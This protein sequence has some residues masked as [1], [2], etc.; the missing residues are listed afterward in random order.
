MKADK[1]HQLQ[2]NALADGVGR[3]VQGMR[4]SPTSRSTLAWVFVVLAIVVVV[5]WQYAAHATQAQYSAL[6]SDV[7]AASHDAVDGLD[8]LRQVAGE[9]Q[10]TF[11]ARSARFEFARLVLQ[12]GQEGIRNFLDRENAVKQLVLARSLYQKLLPECTDSTIL[13]HEAMMGIAQ[14]EESLVGVPNPDNPSEIFD[15]NTALESYRKLAEQ[16]KAHPDSPLAQ[17]A[18]RRVKELDSK[19][20]EIERFYTDLNSWARRPTDQVPKL[21]MPPLPT[22]PVPALPG[23]VPSAGPD[24]TPPKETPK[25][26]GKT[27]TSPPPISGFTPKADNKPPKSDNKPPAVDTKPKATKSK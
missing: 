24:L 21:E 14:A 4:S 9:N 25:T 17:S 10:G 7:N 19:H 12:R 5:I 15:L 6:W 1:R 13:A 20:A 11:P 27:P 22:Q 3:L 23:S 16:T 18:E 2:R 26:D 8:R